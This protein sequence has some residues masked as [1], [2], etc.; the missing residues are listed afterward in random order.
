[1]ARHK[2][3]KH[4]QSDACADARVC[5]WPQAPLAGVPPV[6]LQG[7]LPMQ[8]GGLACAACPRVP[9]PTRPGPKNLES[10]R[11]EKPVGGGVSMSSR[12]T[13]AA[14][15]LLAGDG[16]AVAS[17]LREEACSSGALSSPDG[18]GG[19]PRAL[20]PWSAAPAV[21]PMAAAARSTRP[22]RARQHQV[23]PVAG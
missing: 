11:M 16:A 12:T 8:A 15:P 2:A 9:A 13:L 7:S 10:W 18:S 1:M 19:A 4:C 5:G 22:R 3:C 23:A 6:L 20:E 17:S 21:E 14:W